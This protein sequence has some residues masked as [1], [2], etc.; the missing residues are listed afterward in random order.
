MSLN[1]STIAKRLAGTST[2]SRLAIFLPSGK[3]CHG[4]VYIEKRDCRTA[5][6]KSIEGWGANHPARPVLLTSIQNGVQQAK[7]SQK[8][9]ALLDNRI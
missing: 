9:L 1:V 2:G 7:S 8:P 6:I 3:V 5:G 4:A